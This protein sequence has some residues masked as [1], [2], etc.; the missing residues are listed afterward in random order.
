[1]KICILFASPRK[2][3]NTAALLTPFKDQLRSMDHTYTQFDLYDMNILPC[4][5]CRECQK[6]WDRPAC[7]RDDDADMI[8]REM[9]VSD[10]IVLASPIYAW[11]C[12]APMKALLDRAVYALNKYYG[13]RKGPSL[14]KGKK[15]AI[16]TT[17]GYKPEKGADLFQEGIRRYC[18]HSQL[19]YISMLA[20]RHLGY[21]TVF[22]DEA[23]ADHARSFA[24]EITG[25]QDV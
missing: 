22:M 14:W 11:Y 21:D 24:R 16:I 12:T 5:A 6:D 20:E 8:F 3:G 17:C 7:I 1:M 10:I 23:K 19:E 13:D 4:L 15:V 9:L 2:D 18:R 25:G